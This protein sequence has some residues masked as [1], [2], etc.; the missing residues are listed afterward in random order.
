MI[1]A[2]VDQHLEQQ[3]LEILTRQMAL[4]RRSLK[5]AAVP[6]EL[7]RNS[8]VLDDAMVGPTV[9]RSAWRTPVTRFRINVERVF[10]RFFRVDPSRQRY[11]EGTGLGRLK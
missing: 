1:A 4:A 9:L 8:H 10:D 11:G 7:K 3:D 6:D 2:A 5:K